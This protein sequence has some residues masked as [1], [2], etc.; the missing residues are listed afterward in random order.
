MNEEKN[1]CALL[2]FEDDKKII[3]I[4]FGGTEVDVV[5]N[6]LKNMNTAILTGLDDN[7]IAI[8]QQIFEMRW[9]GIR[10]ADAN[11]NIIVKLQF[12]TPK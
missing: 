6:Y 11:T 7:S 9:R 4:N 1:Q 2:Q 5:D 8:L 10:V 3:N 12:L